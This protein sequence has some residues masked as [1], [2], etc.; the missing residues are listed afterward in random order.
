MKYSTRLSDA[1]HILAFIYLNEEP[2][3]TSS[4]IAQS[5]HTNPAVVRKFMS[6]MK[7]HGLIVNTQGHPEPQMARDPSEISLLDVYRAVE[8]SKPL[9]HLDTHINPECGVGVLI[10]ESLGHF[11]VEIQSEAERKMSEI[12]LGDII[13]NYHSLLSESDN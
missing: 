8:G 11:Y 13:D 6:E 9:L 12:S 5:I 10:Q 7:R 3:L 4:R 2:G 1:V